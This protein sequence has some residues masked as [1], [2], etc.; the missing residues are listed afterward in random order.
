MGKRKIKIVS[1]I[2]K[3]INKINNKYYLGSSK[4]IYKRY[5]NHLYNLKIQKHHCIH[6]QNAYNKYGKNNFYL[7]IVSVIPF[8]D[9]LEEELKLVEQSL[10]DDLDY[11]KVYNVSASASGGDLISKHPNKEEIINKRNNKFRAYLN[12]LTR[13]EILLRSS[14]P[15]NLNPN[16]RGGHKYFCNCGKPIQEINKTCS[17]CRNRSGENNPFYGKSHSKEIK[18]KIAKTKNSLPKKLPSNTRAVII[19][20][21]YYES[22]T[23]AS[24]I[25]EVGAAL[26]LFR[27]KSKNKRFVGYKYVDEMPNDHPDRE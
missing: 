19:D 20:G 27:I 11:S 22:L 4:D 21:I 16:W 10:L 5:K 17:K 26:I 3:I 18:N 2:Y 25:L 14:R 12:S 1:G 9:K 23:Q 15:G 13:E 8:S 6:L 7:E 24:K